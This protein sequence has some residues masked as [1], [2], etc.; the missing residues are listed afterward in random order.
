[1]S[2]TGISG[3]IHNLIDALKQA[4]E[5][6]DVDISDRDLEDLAGNR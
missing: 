6:L 5:Q 4:L 1:M 2:K 3:T